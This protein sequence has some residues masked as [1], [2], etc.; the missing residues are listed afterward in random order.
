MATSG[1]SGTQWTAEYQD[2]SIS[3]L[4]LE[5]I[6]IPVSVTKNGAAYNPT[7]DTVQFAYMPTPTGVPGSGNWV[8]GSWQTNS[9][10]I[11]YPYSA[12]CLTGP[13]GTVNPGIGTYIIYIEIT[14]N[15]E[16][17]VLIGGQLE[18]T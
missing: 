16:V 10:N 4:S 12:V 17:P 6:L 8:T 5:D 9:S 1:A 7:S 18:I 14:D 15:P 11:L 13:G 2:V 3:H